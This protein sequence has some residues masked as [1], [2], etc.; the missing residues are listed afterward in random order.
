MW[1]QP[2]T[3]ENR[4]WSSRLPFTNSDLTSCLWN[5]GDPKYEIIY[6]HALNCIPK[7]PKEKFIGHTHTMTTFFFFVV[8]VSPR[9]MALSSRKFSRKSKSNARTSSA[10]HHPFYR[11]FTLSETCTS[12]PA[13]VFFI[14]SSLLML[15]T[16]PFRLLLSVYMSQ[17]T[18][19]PQAP[20]TGEGRGGSPRDF[21]FFCL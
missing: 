5:S 21:L 15:T 3:A 11:Q 12:Q 2:W 6:S 20:P 19:N 13:T 4:F 18:T 9:E 10:S 8:V 1:C 7:P 16:L 17:T 14:I